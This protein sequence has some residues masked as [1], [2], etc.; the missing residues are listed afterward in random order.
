MQ[1]YGQKIVLVGLS[2]NSRKN[3]AKLSG[4]MLK[5]SSNTNPCFLRVTMKIKT[6][7]V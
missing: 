7:T 5:G 2:R 3:Y 1:N 6:V 4:K